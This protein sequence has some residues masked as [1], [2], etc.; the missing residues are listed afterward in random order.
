[1]YINNLPGQT[2]KATTSIGVGGDLNSTTGAVRINI[3][4]IGTGIIVVELPFGACTPPM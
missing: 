3:P 4:G 2:G 1:L